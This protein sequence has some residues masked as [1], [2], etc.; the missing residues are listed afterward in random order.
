MASF[1]ARNLQTRMGRTNAPDRLFVGAL[2]NPQAWR[3]LTRGDW[4]RAL[5]A[6]KNEYGRPADY[7]GWISAA[8]V[9]CD[10][11]GEVID[12]IANYLK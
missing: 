11:A 1:K 8:G 12:V 9:H 3:N 10:R 4:G 7:H 2:G 5:E 6:L